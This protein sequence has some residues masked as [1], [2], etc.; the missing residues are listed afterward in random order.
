MLL[1][2]ENQKNNPHGGLSYRQVYY[3]D[4]KERLDDIMKL[5][6]KRVDLHKTYIEKTYY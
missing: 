5:H 1:A 2:K 3:R 4:N 6:C